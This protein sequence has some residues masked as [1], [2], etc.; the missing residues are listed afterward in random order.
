MQPQSLSE[1]EAER[2]FCR[3]TEDKMETQAELR[4][5]AKAE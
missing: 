1:R 4:D 2:G 5:V 3:H